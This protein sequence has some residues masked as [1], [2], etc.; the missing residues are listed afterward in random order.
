MAHSRSHIANTQSAQ[1][2]IGINGL[3]LTRGEDTGVEHTVGERDQC[4]TTGRRGQHPQ[5]ARRHTTEPNRG[6]SGGHFT[7]DLNSVAVQREAG[8]HRRGE[9]YRDEGSRG[10]RDQPCQQHQGSQNRERQ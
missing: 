10:A 3:T 5:V 2:R 8:H 6:Q 9:K 1:F 4:H 7:D